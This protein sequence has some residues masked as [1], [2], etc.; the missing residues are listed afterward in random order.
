MSRQLLEYTD[1]KYAETATIASLTTKYQASQSGLSDSELLFIRMWRVWRADHIVRLGSWTLGYGGR[2]QQHGGK[3]YHMPPLS[4][5][6]EM[7][8]V[9]Y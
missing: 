5:D 8:Q 1:L 7:E 4:L 9:A 6:K 3:F 2:Q